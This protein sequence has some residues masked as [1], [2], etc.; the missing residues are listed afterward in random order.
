MVV[1]DRRR[2][3][4][5]SGHLYDNLPAVAVALV[6]MLGAVPAAFPQQTPQA[7]A[8]PSK[9]PKVKIAFIGDSTGDGLW[10]GMTQLAGRTACLK[11]TIDLGRF[12]KNSTGLTRPDRLDWVKETQRVGETYK[13]TLFMMSLGL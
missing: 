3:D 9:T 2:Q 10:G 13:P 7:L 4:R 11:T 5:Q 6:I 12:G 8:Q 1:G